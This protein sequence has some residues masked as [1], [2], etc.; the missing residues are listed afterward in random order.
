[1]SI[2]DLNR[3][4]YSCYPFLSFGFGS[5]GYFEVPLL[6]T[7]GFRSSRFCHDIFDPTWQ[8]DIRS[9]F[10]CSLLSAHD[11][12]DIPGCKGFEPCSMSG[13]EPMQSHD[14]WRTHST[15]HLTWYNLRRSRSEEVD[16]L[17]HVDEVHDSSLRFTT[18]NLPLHFQFVENWRIQ[19]LVFLFLM[20]ESRH[21]HGIAKTGVVTL[22]ERGFPRQSV[23]Q[24]SLCGT[25]LWSTEWI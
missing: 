14:S 5:C 19:N 18:P 6:L 7:L 2:F 8:V 12:R 4:Q 22:C 17:V 24:I 10:F 9:N 21:C 25:Q 15:P 11:C 23:S 20:D 13:S 16:T 1:M 3:S